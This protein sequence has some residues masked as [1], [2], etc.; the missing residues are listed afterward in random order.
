VN[1]R[2]DYVSVI[3]PITPAIERVKT[4]LFRPFDL[5]KWFVIGFSA[6]LAELGPKGGG[7]GGGGGGRGGGAPF[8]R[9]DIP[10]EAREFFESAK[11]YIMANLHWIAPVVVF[12]VVIG[13][14]IGLLV[15]WLRSRA[16]F[17]LLYC[18]AQNKS[19]FWI[20]WRQYRQHGGSLF[21]F[22]VVLG[23]VWFLTAGAF[24][25][26]S[27]GLGIASYETLGFNVL[28]I[29]GIV[30]SALLF[31]SSMIVFGLIGMFTTDFVVPIMYRH[32]LTCRQGWR[33]FLEILSHNQGRF[34]LYAIFHVVIGMVIAVL[35]V[36]IACGTC[37]I[38]CC[39]F[40]IPYIGAVALLPFKVFRRSYSLYYLAQYGPDFYVFAP[41]PVEP[42]AVQ[43]SV[44]E[45][46]DGR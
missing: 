25:T 20:P 27:I 11:G 15:I 33:M 3:D 12:L 9:G 45:P 8:R 37:L 18:V 43:P 6:W 7:N 2:P 46:W 4:V 44:G 1:P 22:R 29:S 40:V 17:S 24:L 35:V 30:T 5:G 14:A 16:Q 19:E 41:E 42:P 32:A 39:L 23:I 34:I 13:V 10:A 36:A 38:A 31:I 21:A 28:T 26:L